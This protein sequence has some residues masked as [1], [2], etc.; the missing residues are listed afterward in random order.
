MTQHLNSRAAI[1]W[2]STGD[3]LVEHLHQLAVP[4]R[5]VQPAYSR[6]VYVSESLDR[7]VLE[8]VTVGN[9][10]YELVGQVIFDNNPQ[11]LLELLKAGDSGRTL[12]YYPDLRDPNVNY[13]CR[14]IGPRGGSLLTDLDGQRGTMGDAAVEL[15]LRPL[16]N[17]STTPFHPLDVA[18]NVLFWLRAG[19][20]I[21]GATFSRAS[22]GRYAAAASGG[23][24]TSA[25][26]NR[27]RLH[28]VDTDRDRIRDSVA[29]LLEGSRTNLVT[30]NAIGGGSWSNLNTP[31]VTTGVADPAGGTAAVTIED[32]NAATEE[33]RFI[34]VTYTGNGTKAVSAFVK[35]GTSATSVLLGR[36]A[37]AGVVRGGVLATWTGGVPVLT[38]VA[39]GEVLFGPERYR[40]DYWRV[41]FAAAGHVAANTNRVQLYGSSFATAAAIGTTTWYGPQAENANTMSSY[42]VTTGST[43]T[44]SADVFTTP[45]TARPQALTVYVR[46]I[47][48]GIVREGAQRDVIQIGQGATGAT[49]L[50]Y[51]DAGGVFTAYVQNGSGTGVTSAAAVSPVYGDLVELSGALTADGRVQLSQ[52]I[53]GAA[54]TTA[55]QSVATTNGLPMAWNA[56]LI[57]LS[58]TTG[59]E[60]TFLGLLNVAIV[61][62][63]H[64]LEAMRRVARVAA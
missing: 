3:T 12:T 48:F 54:I 64:T 63:V 43:Q 4:L 49:F 31:I 15:R 34:G 38:G 28:H 44:R 22:V 41:G 59:L 2:S 7:T 5:R 62:G 50:L 14:L 37:T 55:A 29:L 13:P 40:D 26:S 52:S 32:D 25:A 20:T 57:V 42:I 58:G 10:A 35:R 27:L 47:E 36:D 33:G 23:T 19:D 46:F 24:D 1:T 45:L 9:G 51:V 16:T 6:S 61:R 39:G 18:S 30:T 53:N 17:P 21:T 11:Q 60:Q 8:T 56:N